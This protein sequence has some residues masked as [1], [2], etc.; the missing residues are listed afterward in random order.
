MLRPPMSKA[1]AMSFCA[2]AVSGVAGSVAGR[3]LVAAVVA[4]ES[5]EDSESACAT[6][7]CDAGGERNRSCL[8]PA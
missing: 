8:E 2:G 3:S 4:A 6:H 1:P 5:A 7:Q